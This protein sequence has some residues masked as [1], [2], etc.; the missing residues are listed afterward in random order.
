[1]ALREWSAMEW[2]GDVKIGGVI[3]FLISIP[4]GFLWPTQKKK[5][6]KGKKKEK[7][8]SANNRV[9]PQVCARAEERCRK[10]GVGDSRHR[11]RDIAGTNTHRIGL[12]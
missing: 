6:K 1:M 3:V 10:S 2:S 7:M 9:F 12:Q 8:S 5:E 11:P 4:R